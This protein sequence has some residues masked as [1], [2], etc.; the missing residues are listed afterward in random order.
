MLCIINYAHANFKIA[1]VKRNVACRHWNI[2]ETCIYQRRNLWQGEIFIILSFL[3]LV[4]QD[5]YLAWDLSSKSWDR[6]IAVKIVRLAMSGYADS[7]YNDSDFHNSMHEIS[8]VV[9]IST[10]NRQRCRLIF[11][12]TVSS[13]TRFRRSLITPWLTCR[14]KVLKRIFKPSSK[15]NAELIMCRT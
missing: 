8:D 7:S 14:M 10:W 4:F 13:E 12:V 1:N 11:G 9:Y 2:R 15:S 3:V 5:F 6:E